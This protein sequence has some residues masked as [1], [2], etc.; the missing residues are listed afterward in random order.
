M[1]ERLDTIFSRYTFTAE[2]ELQALSFSDLQMQ[3]LQTEAATAAESLVAIA[4]DPQN[5][6]LAMLQNAYYRGQVDIL[7]FM[8]G[9]STDR[10]SEF[11]KLMED[12]AADQKA[13]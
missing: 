13:S 7:K 10:R 9:L 1:S 11:Q 5:Q 8:M 4:Y 3:Y 6:A 12:K 2:E